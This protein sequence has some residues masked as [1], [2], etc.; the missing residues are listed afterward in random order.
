ME[1]IEQIIEKW[2]E[3]LN[4][5]KEEHEISEVSFNT[6]LKPLSVFAVE[7][8]KLYILVPDPIM[9]LSLFFRNRQ[10]KSNLIKQKIS[11]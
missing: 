1:Q 9:R 3:I 7:N 4:T 2:D 10:R 11:G 5:V 6:W 8:N